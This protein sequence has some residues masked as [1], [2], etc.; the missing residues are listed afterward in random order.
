M[1]NVANIA[2]DAV[3]QQQ[4]PDCR[5]TAGPET[6]VLRGSAGQ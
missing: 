6:L 4:A 2:A 5:A 3:A 1:I